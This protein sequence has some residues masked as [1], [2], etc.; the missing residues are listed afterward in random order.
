MPTPGRN[1]QTD[2]EW[3]RGTEQR[4]RALEQ[5]QSTRVGEWVISS[6]DGELVAT[7]PGE[8]LALGQAAAT[9]TSTS[10][11]TRG[12]VIDTVNG[13]VQDAQDYTDAGVTDAKD[14]TDGVYVNTVDYVDG[15]VNDATESIAISIANPNGG[16]GVPVIKDALNLKW[17]DIVEVTEIADARTGAG[18]NM[19]SNPGT[20]KTQFFIG[21]GIFVPEVHRTGNQ[22]VRLTSNGAIRRYYLVTNADGPKQVTCTPG[23]I[24]YFEMWV[25]G[26][27]TNTQ[28]TGGAGALAPYIQVYTKDG[29][30]YP[31]IT[32]TGLTASNAL[33]GQWTRFYGYLT[34]PSGWYQ[35]AYCVPYIQMNPNV[36]YGESYYFDDVIMRADSLVNSWN[37]IYDGAN[38]TVGSTGKGPTDVYTPIKNVKD[39]AKNAYDGAT[40]AAAK[41][42]QAYN[43]A[44]GAAA[45]ADQAYNG[46]TGAQAFGQNVLD[47]VYAGLKNALLSPGFGLGELE[48]AARDAAIGISNLNL[49]T[50][51]LLAQKSA[52]SFY[53]TASNETFGTYASTSAVMPTTKWANLAGGTGNAAF[54]VS[55]NV[56]LR[57]VA[58]MLPLTGTSGTRWSQTRYTTQTLTRFQRIAVVVEAADYGPARNPRADYRATYIYGRMSADLRRYVYAK[59]TGN[60]VS[61]GYNTGAVA[62]PA[63]ETDIPNSVKSYT[64]KSGVTYWFECG[65]GDTA[66]YTYRLF[67]NGTSVTT[68]IDSSAASPN[69][70]TDSLGAGFGGSIQTNDYSPA[71][72]SG[73]ALYDNVPPTYRGS[74]FRASNSTATNFNLAPVAANNSTGAFPANWFNTLNYMT[75]DMLYS[76]STNTL[77]IG[78]PGWYHVTIQQKGSYTQEIPLNPAI[79]GRAA[80]ALFRDSGSGVFNIEQIGQETAVSPL[81]VSFGN[82]FVL[83]CKGGDRLR[84]GYWSTWT[85]TG[86]NSYIGTT[87]GAQTYWTVTFI[88]NIL[89]KD[90]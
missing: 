69:S 48:K 54:G 33:N 28:V 58:A 34:I 31:E 50:S 90:S 44:T 65:V 15:T 8:T 81:H 23:D 5:G 73:F 11:V 79:T 51:N 52:G 40:G 87:L 1:P 18:N 42:D 76:S 4:L 45:K 14:Y 67:E 25:W 57:R 3:A 64:L 88:Q 46:A 13:G 59:F 30:A 20:E 32:M 78:T 53:G 83:Y 47:G 68:G 70:P 72:F 10:D 17:N 27:T 26:K 9:T 86:T 82:S 75:S 35:A 63:G 41:A 66:Q 71:T 84:P 12:F 61:I 22:S 6:Q 85:T 29:I 38:G 80:A 19:V 7:K 89:T 55:D 24:F 21:E 74:G 56:W 2:A 37:Y 39:Q 77:T 43:G 36:T 16:A 62:G 49:I 60:T